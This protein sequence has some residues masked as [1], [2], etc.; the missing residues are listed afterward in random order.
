MTTPL[1]HLP[2]RK[3]RNSL[4]KRSGL[5][6]PVRRIKRKLKNFT[7]RYRL[8]LGGNIFLTA[9]MEY[10][11]T[12]LLD[13]CG[14]VVKQ[15]KRK[16]IIPSHIRLAMLNYTSALRLFA[17]RGL[18]TLCVHRVALRAPGVTQYNLFWDFFS[19]I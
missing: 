14:L 6:F 11:V 19:F 5:E 18:W 1:H 3:K 4:S 16:R 12:E 8:A 9:V 10:L 13:S 2:S 17:L 7:E 15:L